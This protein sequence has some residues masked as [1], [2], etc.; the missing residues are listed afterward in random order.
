MGA[1]TVVAL[2]VWNTASAVS[3]IDDT[4]SVVS[5]E[6]VVDGKYL[7]IEIADKTHDHYM[8]NA[9]LRLAM[10]EA[11]EAA[12]PVRRYQMGTIWL[13][14]G[15]HA[16]SGSP[17]VMVTIAPT[18]HE[19][20]SPAF[21]PVA[22]RRWKPDPNVTYDL[23]ALPQMRLVNSPNAEDLDRL[24][25]VWSGGRSA[26]VDP[27][28][29]TIRRMFVFVLIGLALMVAAV[30]Y[31]TNAWRSTRWDRAADVQRENAALSRLKSARDA[32]RS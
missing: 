11:V 15:Q 17:A 2:L 25:E 32:Q 20:P 3:S 24:R 9:A 31:R 29:S 12:N 7:G 6:Q 8:S 16:E 10:H 14:D 26:K 30:A 22:V 28:Y 4:A 13:H 27:L 18:L 21:E 19:I 5:V 1:V 23:D